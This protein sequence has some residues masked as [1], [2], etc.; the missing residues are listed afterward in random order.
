MIPEKCPSCDANFD[1]GPIP[2]EHRQHYSPPYR[3]SRVISV[4]DRD[5][6]RHGHWRCPDCSHEW[7]H[8]R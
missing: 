6:D 5:A 4:Y 2:E 8:C 3:F 7:G 1:A